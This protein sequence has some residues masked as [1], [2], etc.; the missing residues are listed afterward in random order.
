MELKSFMRLLAA[1][2]ATSCAEAADVGVAD[3]WR[4][5]VF[6][7]TPDVSLC[8]ACCVACTEVSANYATF[9]R[10]A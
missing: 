9:S 8:F 4:R 5:S 2:S 7:I 6:Y 3:I 10:G 1:L